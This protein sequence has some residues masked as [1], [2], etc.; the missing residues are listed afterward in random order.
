MRNI[1]VID[2][3]FDIELAS[4][5]HLSIQYCS[6]NFSFVIRDASGTN[7][8][9]YKS[10]WFDKPVQKQEMADQIRGFLNADSFLTRSY[11]SVQFLYQTPVSV[12]V[13]SALFR[14]ENPEA[15]FRF[16][17]D[18]L[19]EE[20][21]HYRKIPSIDA[22]VLF[23]MPEDLINQVSFMLDKVQ[24]FHQ[25]CP[26]IEA[27][28]A[29][30]SGSADSSQVFAHINPGSADLLVVKQNKLIL[31]NS[32]VIKNTEDLVFF[33]LYLYEQFGLSQEETALNLSGFLERYPG[34]IELLNQYLKQA[35]I[36]KFP[37]E[38]SFSNCFSDIV[39]HHLVS[40]INLSRCE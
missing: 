23:P 18:L 7:F 38:Y 5:Y 9:A 3:T 20:K 8:I 13:P 30:T 1:A 27:A 22:F 17:A 33:I 29:E 28:M 34:A 26:Q 21:V 4:T 2:D 39:Q 37:K 11:K 10:H 15:Y 19:E 12:L 24:F 25:A 35:E 32:F 14:K 6:R 36:S 31:Y 40:I 16:S